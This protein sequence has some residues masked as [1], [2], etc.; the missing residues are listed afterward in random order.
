MTE[1]LM[2]IL[3]TALVNN[4]VLVK[5]LGL[6]PFMG[7]SNKLDSALGMGL[8]TTFVLTLAA[9]AS[10]LLQELVLEP[11][12]IGFLRILTFI[13]VI[14]AVVQFTEMVVRKLSPTLYQ[15]LG[16]FLPLITT[17]CAVL[18]VALLNV[19]EHHGFLESLVYGFGSAL[20]FTLV[21]VLFAGLRERLALAQVPAAFAG[22]PI[23]LVVAGLLSLAFM[24]FAGL[25]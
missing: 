9:G 6:C 25:A 4:V 19:Q 21:M 24:G 2:L 16:I 7:V 14:A 18:G 23:A 17:N 5:F 15:V 20:G 13:L 11:L 1:Y 10:W 8:A 12:N 3:A 22:T